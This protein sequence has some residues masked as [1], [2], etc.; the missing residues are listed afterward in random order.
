MNEAGSPEFLPAPDFSGENI[1]VAVI[2]GNDMDVKLLVVNEKASVKELLLGPET[3]IGRSPECQ[4]RISSSRIS[5]KHCL[6]CV[7]EKTVTVRDLGSSNGTI[8][9]GLTVA[10]GVD[11]IVRP[12]SKLVVGPMKFVFDFEPPETVDPAEGGYVSPTDILALA[13]PASEEDDTKDYIPNKSRQNASSDQASDDFAHD[14]APVAESLPADSGTA[15]PAAVSADDTVY[16]SRLADHAREAARRSRNDTDSALSESG[17]DLLHELEPQPP[18][19]DRPSKGAADDPTD[20]PEL[21][22]FLKQFGS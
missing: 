6:I 8:L 22:R 4:L 16:D 10:P 20:D 3:Y 14:V 12:G 13:A 1:F 2:M 11:A 18:A 5:R 21:V 19:A 7:D 15:R 9:D 17:T